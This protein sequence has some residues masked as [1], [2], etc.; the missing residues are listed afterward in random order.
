MRLLIDAASCA[1]IG[2]VILSGVTASRSEAVAQSKDPYLIRKDAGS[3]ARA[4]S[5]R[6]DA[7]AQGDIKEAVASFQMCGAL[8][9]TE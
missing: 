7:I 2:A 9:Q 8:L 6:V 3:S 1:L 4:P 5:L